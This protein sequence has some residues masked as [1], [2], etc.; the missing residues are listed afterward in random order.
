MSGQGHATKQNASILKVQK[1][2]KLEYSLQ[3]AKILTQ[4]SNFSLAQMRIIETRLDSA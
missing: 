2:I 4:V 3:T 1:K